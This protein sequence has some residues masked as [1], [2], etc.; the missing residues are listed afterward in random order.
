MQEKNQTIPVSAPKIEAFFFLPN[1]FRFGAD[2]QLTVITGY[3]KMTPWILSIVHQRTPQSK[4]G[5][6]TAL[7]VAY[8][9]EFAFL[10]LFGMD[11]DGTQVRIPLCPEEETALYTALQY[12]VQL[13]FG[14]T[15]ENILNLIRE[16]ENLPHLPK[17]GDKAPKRQIATA[18]QRS[19]SPARERK[20]AGA[21][22]TDQ[23][24]AH[25]KTK[26]NQWKQKNKEN[27]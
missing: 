1:H 16:N 9:V 19:P 18:K 17:P 26:G 10:G 8:D 7:I 12:A 13:H 21:N 15:P 24:T 20:K 25:Q 11:A 6:P 5:E 4:A 27:R 2:Q 14:D 22:Q 23:N 3:L